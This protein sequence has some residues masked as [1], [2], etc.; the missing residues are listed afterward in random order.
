MKRLLL[1]L[2]LVALLFPG[3]G[4]AVELK[5]QTVCPA[6]GKKIKKAVYTD[7]QD[8]RIYFC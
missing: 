1:L 5:P 6:F 4:F 2:I 3:A 7:Y 8:Q